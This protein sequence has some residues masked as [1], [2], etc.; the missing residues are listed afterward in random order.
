MTRQTHALYPNRRRWLLLLVILVAVYVLLPQVGDFRSSWHVMSHP[1]ALPVITAIVLTLATFAA[2]A[3]TYCILAFHRLRYRRTLLVQVAANFVDRLLPAGIGGLGA[4]YLYLR[5]ERHSATQAG[6]TVAINNL[7]GFLGHMLLIILLLVVSH[8]SLEAL[9]W[10]G[11]DPSFLVKAVLAVAVVLVVAGLLFG[12][13]R[14]QKVSAN[15]KIQ[16]K[17]WRRRKRSLLAALGTSLILTMCNAL[18][19]LCCLHALNVQLPFVSVLLA[20]TVGLGAGSAVLTPGGIGG[21]EAGLAAS[22]AAYGV[23]A[24]AALA[25]ALLYR[26]IS[27][28][29]PLIIGAA[30][31]VVCERR[32][33][34]KVP[35]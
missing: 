17:A 18:S 30:A 8:N 27:Y 12:R 35:S 34:F 5:H 31:F 11:P 20:F 28:W 15:V 33:L 25:L 32:Q 23:D 4:N 22:F 16:L 2:A 24:P 7:L 10:H 29:L 19:L 9:H 21:F 1:R 13:E 14:F 26:L 3:G 6:S